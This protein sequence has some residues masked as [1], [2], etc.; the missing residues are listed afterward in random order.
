MKVSLWRIMGGVTC[1]ACLLL[2]VVVSVAAGASQEASAGV[3]SFGGLES[4]LAGSPG[5]EVT[6]RLSSPE[7]LAEDAQS[8]MAFSGYG[9]AQAVALA[10][11]VFGVG[12]PQWDASQDPG[13]GRITGYVGED[14]AAEVLPDGQHVLLDSSM[15]LRSVLGSGQLAPVSLSLNASGESY[16]P[17]NPLVPVVIGK[18]AAEGVSFQ[19]GL[20]TYHPGI[21]W[22]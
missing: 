3:G 10:K 2:G 15:P 12:G 8:R 16:V 11:R 7:A 19:F 14:A 5:E 22:W 13:A 18:N 4:P 17:A 21:W 1:A 6:G 20:P 9:R